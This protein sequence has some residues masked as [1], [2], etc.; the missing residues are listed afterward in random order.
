M[1]LVEFALLNF[2]TSIMA[3]NQKFVVYITKSYNISTHVVILNLCLRT[4]NKIHLILETFSVLGD[5]ID[6]FSFKLSQA[7]SE[8]PSMAKLKLRMKYDYNRVLKYPSNIM[9]KISLLMTFQNWGTADNFDDN[10]EGGVLRVYFSASLKPKLNTEIGL[11][12]P[13]TTK[14][15]TNSR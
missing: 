8:Y 11:H 1:F 10:L 3:Y 15:L 4:Q 12:H 2:Y 9:I 7:S 13:P 6:M 14:L 5:S